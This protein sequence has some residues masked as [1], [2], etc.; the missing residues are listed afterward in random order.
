[1]LQFEPHKNFISK[2]WIFWTLKNLQGFFCMWPFHLQA[3]TS[4]LRVSSQ[5]S[6]SRIILI[7]KSVRCTHARPWICRTR[8]RPR[9]GKL[10]RNEKM[11][12]SFVRIYDTNLLIFLSM[13]HGVIWE[14]EISNFEWQ[15]RYTQY[16]PFTSIYA[17]DSWSGLKRSQ[18]RSRQ[19]FAF[20]PCCLIGLSLGFASE[21]Q[22][23]P[24]LSEAIGYFPMFPFEGNGDVEWR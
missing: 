10:G 9:R 12:S 17:W 3:E 21:L 14:I 24:A 2:W 4:F 11:V 1:M 19:M 7:S 13:E 16:A 5:V 8:K 22:F 15:Y 18:L 20:Y 6:G 23:V